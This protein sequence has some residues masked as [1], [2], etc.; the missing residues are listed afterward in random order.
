LPLTLAQRLALLIPASPLSWSMR[1]MRLAGAYFCVSTG[2]ALMIRSDLGIAP[3]DTLITGFAD[4]TNINFGVAFIVVSAIF[5]VVGWMLGSPPGPG[6]VLG[7]LVIGNV[8]DVLLQLVD[9]DKPLVARIV[10]F[11]LGIVG[12]AV[13]ICLAISTNLG[14]GPSE[15]LMLGLHR[16][17]VPLIAA[18]WVVDG[19][20]L[21]LGFLLGGPIGIGTA[22]FLVVMAP[23][24]KVGLRWLRYSPPGDPDV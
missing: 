1:L 24:I 4:T 12:V 17:G 5:Y 16:K 14:P 15:V 18:R 19:I 7:S 6:S 10:F 21:G 20:Q 23:M 22:I 3:T 13:G 8:I 11:A 2:I 9:D